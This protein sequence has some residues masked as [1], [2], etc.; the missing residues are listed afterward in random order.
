MRVWRVSIGA[1]HHFDW[2]S[3]FF[4]YSPSRVFNI[5]SIEGAEV[6]LVRTSGTYSAALMV[7]FGIDFR[8]RIAHETDFFFTP[9]LMLGNDRMDGTSSP[10]RCHLGYG[11]NFGVHKYFNRHTSAAP[12]SFGAWFVRDASISFSG[13]IQFQLAD[14]TKRDRRLLPFGA[15]ECQ[16]FIHASAI[17]TVF[18]QI[19]RLLRRRHLEGVQ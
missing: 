15:R 7:N 18:S 2:T 8:A 12:E 5:S 14:I 9:R 3:Y 10:D 19:V 11:F 13:G 4:G 17:R 1:S 16:H 6:G